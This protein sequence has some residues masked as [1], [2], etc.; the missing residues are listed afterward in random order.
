[1]SDGLPTDDQLR[2]IERGVQRRIDL[3]RTVAH[4]V[5][6]SAAAV[7][8]IGG[9]FA[10]LVPL[11]LSSGAS[12]GSA[13]AGGT[14]ASAR[15]AVQVVCHDSSAR[16]SASRRSQVPAGADDRRLIAACGA[17][18]V[19]FQSAT[20]RVPSA[21]SADGGSDA[22][23][24]SGSGSTDQGSGVAPSGSPSSSPRAASAGSASPSLRGPAVLCEATDGV[25][26][27][28]PADARPTT[29]CARNGMRAR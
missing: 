29:L 9:G 17:D 5:V 21:S 19:E 10:L 4:R 8:L 23:S 3:R 22:G 7:A 11:G 12:G 14:A 24:G 26:H 6:G 25:L 18:A 27:V 15:A 2:R 28:F 16:D 1:M 20:G 13:A